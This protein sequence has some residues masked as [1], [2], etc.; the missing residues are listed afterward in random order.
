MGL[1]KGGKRCV[2][3]GDKKRYDTDRNLQQ[4]WT[5]YSPEDQLRDQLAGRV[6]LPVGK[7]CPWCSRQREK[8]EL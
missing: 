5:F 3:C 1:Q 2:H 4:G 6:R 8:V 7:V